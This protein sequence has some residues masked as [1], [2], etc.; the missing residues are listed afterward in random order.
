MRNIISFFLVLTLILP[1]F[2]FAQSRTML[3]ISQPTMAPTITSYEEIC[4]SQGIA[5]VSNSM[6]Q[7]CQVV[8]KDKMCESVPQK[9]RLNCNALNNLAVVNQWD[10]IVG[11]AKGAFNSVKDTLSFF[12]EIMK[13]A[14]NNATSSEARSKSSGA[15]TEF[16]N[17]AKLFLHTE[18][19]KAHA[20][21]KPP[22]QDVKA[23][24]AMG[25]S[26]GKLIMGKLSDFAAQQYQQLGCMNFQ[27]K[28][29][30]MCKIVGD[31]FLPP[32]GVV[33]LLKYGSKAAKQF[34]KVATLFTKKVAPV[35]KVAPTP[36]A[37][38]KPIPKPAPKQL[39]GP[40]PQKLLTGPA[41]QKLLPAPKPKTSPKL[42]VMPIDDVIKKHPK[43]AETLESLKNV[44]NIP[45]ASK[46]ND[47]SEIPF[48]L[49]DTFR[50]T[51]ADGMRARAKELDPEIN[52]SI[53]AAYNTLNDP[54]VLKD[55]YIDLYKEA[56]GWM[57]KKGTKADLEYLERGQVSKHAIAVVVIRRLKE[58]GDNQFTTVL[59]GKPLSYGKKDINLADV[60]KANDGFRMAVKTGPFIDRGFTDVS[61]SG[62]GVF[63][64]LI[65][66][67]IVHKAVVKET[68][69]KPEKFWG[70]LGTKKGINW[71]GDLFDSGN[72]ASMTRPETLTGHIS[73]K[74]AME[75]TPVP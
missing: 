59:R 32:A 23:I 19:N 10:F 46:I 14:W 17:S 3:K 15:T 11:C 29:K 66:R 73:H 25:A 53:T 8:V 57:A 74:M 65:Q 20:R 49:S 50:P 7:M 72:S 44:D 47:A 63:S 75:A 64:H 40:A 51:K 28:S 58:R 27:A 54:Q 43:V 33:A 36:K 70:F 24:S 52:R 35:I 6:K 16:M 31:I 39:T 13:W 42:V 26:I 48:E 60:E 69:G 41:P 62:H 2:A 18:Y 4:K 9:D 61:R 55:Y 56:A 5:P 37:V 34:P 30:Y 1:N 38:P 21:A 22:F 67:D 45:V 12:W 71:W 68:N